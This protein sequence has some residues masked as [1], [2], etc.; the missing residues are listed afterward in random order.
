MLSDT[1]G[2]KVYLNEI[3]MQLYAY[4]NILDE[5]GQVFFTFIPVK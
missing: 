1:V 3:D 2:P 5:L 4:Y